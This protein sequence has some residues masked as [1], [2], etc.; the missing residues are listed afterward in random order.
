MKRKIFL[1]SLLVICLAIMTTGT[2]AYFTAKETAHNIITSGGVDIVLTETAD[3][4][5]EI[6]YTDKT[7]IMPGTQVDKYARIN[8]GEDSAEAWL[9]VKFD[10]SI[11]LDKKN[12]DAYVDGKLI[13]PDTSLIHLTMPEEGWI[14]GGDGWFY[15]EQPL[16]QGMEAIALKHVT[17]DVTMSNAYQNAT[18]TV[19]V[20]AQAVQTA[21]NGSTVLEAKGWP[22]E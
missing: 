20:I 10:L 7:G 12:P 8:L 9:R 6:P 21:H 15:Y 14:D 22:A 16:K 5:G 3:E 13:T 2:L 17:F 1:V 4:A 11:T 19:D 18:A